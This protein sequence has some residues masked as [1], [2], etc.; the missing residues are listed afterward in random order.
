MLTGALETGTRSAQKHCAF[1]SNYLLDPIVLVPWIGCQ[2][3][4]QPQRAGSCNERRRKRSSGEALARDAHGKIQRT[5]RTRSHQRA[6][7]VSVLLQE[8][9]CVLNLPRQVLKLAIAHLKV[10]HST[11]QP[12]GPNARRRRA[13]SNVGSR[14]AQDTRHAVYRLN[15][16][17]TGGSPLE[18]R[19]RPMA[20]ARSIHV[21]VP[22]VRIR[23]CAQSRPTLCL[24]RRS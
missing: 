10:S 15:S 7:V 20:G 3:K 23:Q 22:L 5:F 16:A 11:L 1:E 21:G 9:Q 8:F 13:A 18:R 4:S 17:A 6:K 24:S 12:V 19:A 2:V 14:Y